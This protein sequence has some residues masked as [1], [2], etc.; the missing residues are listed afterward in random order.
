M[1][2]LLAVAGLHRICL[3]SGETSMTLS[4]FPA[5]VP[6]PHI[7]HLTWWTMARD[8]HCLCHHRHSN[9]SA[10]LPTCHQSV[11]IYAKRELMTQECLREC[12]CICKC[13]V[14]AVMCSL[15]PLLLIEVSGR[16]LVC[17]PKD[18]K[19]KFILLVEKC[20]TCTKFHRADS[21]YV[22]NMFTDQ[23]F[24]YSKVAMVVC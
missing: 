20:C 22:A 14:I 4:N 16:G 15:C 13:L 21:V 11:N 18:T 1:S 8:V 2:V 19:I 17:V 5:V 6:P 7:H 10:V 12:M 24:V 23:Q 3:C 9:S